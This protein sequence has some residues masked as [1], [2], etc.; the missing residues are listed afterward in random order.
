MDSRS[1]AT[2]LLI[3]TVGF[4]A[5]VEAQTVTFISSLGDNANN[6]AR[7]APCRTLQR[8]INRTPD[9]GELQILDSGA[10]GSGVIKR[11]IT[12][13]ATG[14]AATTGQITVD[15][16]KA[17]VVLRGLLLN[18]GG[19]FQDGMK[20]Q[21]AASVHVLHCE[22]ERFGGSGINVPAQDIKV[23]VAHSAA[24]NNGQAGLAFNSAG[25]G[26]GSVVNSL[27]ESNQLDGM[28]VAGDFNVDIV[29]VVASGN[30]SNGIAVFSPRAN[31]TDSTAANNGSSG[32]VVS[33]SGQLSVSRSV[34]RGNGG[35]GFLANAGT[36]RVSD[37]V[38]TNNAFGLR[39]LGLST[40]Q[41][42]GNNLVKGNGTDAVGTIT[43]I[44]GM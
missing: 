11:S 40:L 16:P 22:V 42:R 29:G 28:N 23:H 30:S 15:A 36:G 43:P 14:V 44:E 3:A 6:C 10:Y 34:A 21:A 19:A 4:V 7:T 9:G 41:S 33:G 2:I 12:I 5:P 17:K 18:G 8:G 13:S 26:T 20:L 35:S 24:R 1:A 38:F 27:F 32:F 37:S 31:V 39:R 25:S